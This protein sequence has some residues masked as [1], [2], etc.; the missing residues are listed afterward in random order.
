MPQ[1]VYRVS[2][3]PK[4]KNV[5]TI[6]RVKAKDE[7]NPHYKTCQLL[8]TIP[9]FFLNYKTATAPPSKQNKHILTLLLL[10]KFFSLSL[11]LSLQE[12]WTSISAST[13]P[14][15]PPSSPYSPSTSPDFPCHRRP[16]SIIGKRNTCRFTVPLGR[17]AS[18]STVLA[19]D[20]TPASPTAEL[21]NGCPNNKPGLISPLLLQTGNF[22]SLFFCFF[23]FFLLII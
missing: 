19:A 7:N 4:W 21:S 5:K 10:L 20:L 2:Q 6:D 16:L 23:F 12:Q 15:S 22:N 13:Q 14:P 8:N 18:P 9:T 1:I 11:F 17:R 3:S